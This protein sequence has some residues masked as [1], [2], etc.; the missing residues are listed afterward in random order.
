[1]SDSGYFTRMGGPPP[2]RADRTDRH[3]MVHAVFSL[4]GL[5]AGA[6]A[7]FV[8]WEMSETI[9]L[10]IFAFFAVNY[11]VGRGVGDLVTDD[12]KI[13][14]FAFFFLP[15]VIDSVLLYLTYQWWGLMWLAVIVGFVLGAA[16]WAPVAVL[17]F[18]DINEEEQRDTK[19]RMEDAVGGGDN[20]AGGSS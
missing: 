13:K 4:I 18:A 6:G 17:A 9:S 3:K 2:R 11:L 20:A 7:A 14:R 5:L 19:A 15:V 12:K 8:A 10:P 16:V 1:M